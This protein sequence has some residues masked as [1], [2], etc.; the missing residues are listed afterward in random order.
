MQNNFAECVMP[1]MNFVI[2][3]NNYAWWLDKTVKITFTKWNI[4]NIFKNF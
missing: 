1:S 2:G 3:Q 4:K